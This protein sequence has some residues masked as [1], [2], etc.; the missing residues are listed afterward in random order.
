MRILLA[1]TILCV[2]IPTSLWASTGDVPPAAVSFAYKVSHT[3]LPLSDT[4]IA[5][6]QTTELDVEPVDEAVEP[7]VING[8]RPRVFSRN[9]LCGSAALVARANNLPVP[10]FA[11][12]IW[13]ESSFDTKVIS[14]VG[15]QGIAQFMPRTAVEFGLLNPFDP[16][17][18]LSVSG[19]FLRTLHQQFGNLGL[20]AAAYNAGPRRVQDWIAKR[21]PLPRETRNYVLRITGRPAE[22][23]IGVRSD[24]RNALMPA[25]APC[26][27][28][29]LALREQEKVIRISDLVMDLADTATKAGAAATPDDGW[30]QET[31]RVAGHEPSGYWAPRRTGSNRP[32]RTRHKGRTPGPS[33]VASKTPEKRGARGSVRR[34]A[35][36]P[37]SRSVRRSVAAA[38]RTA[39]AKRTRLAARP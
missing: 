33:E 6:A 8:A 21:G 30:S 15:A 36:K 2:A 24:M 22:E 28:V 13:Q 5:S 25:K 37:A 39:R 27:E 19:Q 34:V 1:G 12:L 26:A 31:F 23:W 4:A 18:A 9:E 11:N 14:R 3:A 29:A 16:I 7:A 38:A 17:H 10:F 32:A 35:A 20:A